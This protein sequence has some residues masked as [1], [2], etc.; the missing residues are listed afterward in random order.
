MLTLIIL[1]HVGLFKL[2]QLTAGISIFNEDN[3]TAVKWLAFVIYEASLG[4]GLT[5]VLVVIWGVVADEF[6]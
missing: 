1:L 3:Y 6:T 5:A 2:A 4:L